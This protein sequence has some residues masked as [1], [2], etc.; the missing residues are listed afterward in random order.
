MGLFQRRRRR[1]RTAAEQLALDVPRWRGS[2]RWSDVSSVAAEAASEAI[3]AGDGGSYM[4]VITSMREDYESGRR[5]GAWRGRRVEDVMRTLAYRAVGH[6][7]PRA[8][9]MTVEEARAAVGKP[10]ESGPGPWK[11]VMSGKSAL[12]QPGIRRRARKGAEA[13]RKWLRANRP[14]IEAAAQQ[15]GIGMREANS[16]AW[17]AFKTHRPSRRDTP[18]T[19]RAAIVGGRKE[20]TMSAAVRKPS[21]SAYRAQFAGKATKAQKK[22]IQAYAAQ[23]RAKKAGSSKKKGAS[24]RSSSGAKWQ[25]LPA[26]LCTPSGRIRK[27]SKEAFRKY[28]AKTASP[29]DKRH[30]ITYNAWKRAGSP[31]ANTKASLSKKTSSSKKKKS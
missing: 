7:P 3:R 20:T 23:Q 10:W 27:P 14:A 11:P 19:I 9:F 16:L 26:N 1:G 21:K 25:N 6:P 17:A 15:A 28:F 31:P 18:N 29:A 30:V 8:G 22:A 5:R 24:K 4:E 12:T 13:Y 2:P